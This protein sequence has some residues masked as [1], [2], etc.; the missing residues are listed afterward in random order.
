MG[1]N[2]REGDIITN[3][4]KIREIFIALISRIMGNRHQTPDIRLQPKREGKEERENHHEFT[5]KE[6]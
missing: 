5:N 1:G 2:R 4:T 6:E 3:L